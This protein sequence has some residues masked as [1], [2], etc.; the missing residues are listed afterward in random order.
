MALPLVAQ[1]VSG[2]KRVV[3]DKSS[4]TLRAYDNG[5]LFMESRISTGK[6]GKA[7]PSGNFQAGA[8][9]LMHYSKLY[10]NAPM[11]YSV[12]FGGNYFIHGYKS[13]PHHPASH[14]CVRLPIDAAAK[15]YKWVTPGTPITIT[16]QWA[17]SFYPEFLKK[18]H[19]RPGHVS[20][21]F[22]RPNR[23]IAQL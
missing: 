10:H 20:S 9:S 3:I 6:E 16:G 7:T 5:K 22:D 1:A 13:V 8:K 18:Q 23:A 2:G 14:G 17:S 21:T 19:S 11:P 4:Q 12:N 15:F